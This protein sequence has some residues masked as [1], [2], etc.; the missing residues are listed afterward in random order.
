MS[1]NL[2]ITDGTTSFVSA[3]TAA[4]HQLGTVLPDVFTAKEAMEHGHLGGWNV[5]KLPLQTTD[6]R[7]RLINIEGMSAVV[8][9][10]P[11]RKGQV[12]VLSRYGVSDD[13]Q[14]VQ[15]EEHA[16]FLDALVD[17][18]G[19][20]F[21]TAGALDGGRQVFITM[22]MPGHIMVGGKDQVDNYLA[23]FNSHNGSMSFTLMVTPVRVVCANTMNLAFQNHSNIFRV[24]HTVNAQRNILAKAREALDFSFKYLDAFQEEA[25]RLVQTTM[26]QAQFEAIV[27]AEFGAK[28]GASA[29]T[30]TRA[31][32]RLDEMFELFAEANTQ[33]GIRGT[34]W[35][36]LNALTE[37]AD[38]FSVVRGN[39][40][41]GSRAAKA[42]KDPSF[43]NRALA[44]ML[45]HV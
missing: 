35:A 24:R 17:E 15:N 26:T 29:S 32:N 27:T 6:E 44:L 13:Y 30:V 34:A 14:I 23:A 3:H 31:E 12:D 16:A 7:G 20:K 40:P 10:N 2:D 25:N 41:D 42:I 43:K 22:K 39:D 11:V 19:V 4:W 1:H 33:E 21:D 38:H 8:R 36:G 28:E 37:W 5:R 9:D 45:Q 18:G